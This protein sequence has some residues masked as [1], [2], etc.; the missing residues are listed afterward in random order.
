M[1]LYRLYHFSFREFILTKVH[2]D[3]APYHRRWAKLL[4]QWQELDGHERDYALR[5]LPRHLIE[6]ERWDELIGDEEN[7][8]LL[9]DL[10]FIEAKCAAGMGYELASDYNE[11]MAKLPELREE[12]RRSGRRGRNVWITRM[13]WPIT[14]PLNQGEPRYYGISG[15]FDQSPKVEDC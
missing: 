7:P 2:P 9:C 8:G 12:K 4:D 10:R 15:L 5:H 14:A 13:R 3:L 6:S 1:V 11:A